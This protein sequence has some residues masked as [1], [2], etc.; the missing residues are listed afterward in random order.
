MA[1]TLGVANP[2]RYRG[3][4]YDT[5]SGF[6]YLQSRY[7]DPEVGRFLNADGILGANQDILSYNLYA[8]CSNNPV[9]LSDPTGMCPYNGTIADFHR[10]EKGLPSIDCNCWYGKYFGLPD[11]NPPIQA[12]AQL[13]AKEIENNQFIEELV[14]NALTGVG[15]SVTGKVI[16]DQ[17]KTNTKFIPKRAGYVFNE[18]VGIKV[19]QSRP[20][21]LG[22]AV[23]GFS[24]TAGVV[25]AAAYMWDI[26][27]D[28]QHYGG[29]T[30]DFGIAAGITTT[31]TALCIGVGLVCTGAG[32]P[33]GVS[34]LV[35]VAAE[36]ELHMQVIG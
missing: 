13:P 1:T 25:S 11:S 31:M 28:F 10:M 32:A 2:F 27:C 20:A 12:P 8:Y 18:N 33:L 29:F 35:G 24:K 3:Y 30:R 5:E 17:V 9:N 23:K 26:G 7:Y 19:I 16:A 6:Y 22:K 21:T 36:L 15:D 14:G 4:Y 34:L